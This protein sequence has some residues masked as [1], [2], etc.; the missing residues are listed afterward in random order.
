MVNLLRSPHQSPNWSIS[1][2]NRAMNQQKAYQQ[3]FQ[4]EYAGFPTKPLE[5][6]WANLNPMCY[7]VEDDPSVTWR[8]GMI[9]SST[10]DRF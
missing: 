5:E 10:C 8:G 9:N 1:S 3:L 4:G 6:A 7:V 2:W